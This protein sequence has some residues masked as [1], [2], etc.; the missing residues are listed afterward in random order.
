MCKVNYFFHFYVVK[1]TKKFGG[2]FK[3]SDLRNE[4][5]SYNLTILFRLCNL[6]SIV[7]QAPGQLCFREIL[8]S[9]FL[10]IVIQLLIYILSSTKRIRLLC[11]PCPLPF[12]RFLPGKNGG[13]REGDWR[14]A[15]LAGK[16]EEYALCFFAGVYNIWNQA[17][18]S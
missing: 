10:Y 12:G 17:K 2:D 6:N 11:L 9:P 7:L 15:E 3:P 5:A 13:L 4:I 1:H 8:K 14:K 18:S 16:C